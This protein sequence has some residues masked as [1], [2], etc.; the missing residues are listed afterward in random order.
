MNRGAWW[1]RKLAFQEFRAGERVPPAAHHSAGS[2]RGRTRP[3]R[4]DAAGGQVALV[5]CLVALQPGLAIELH[6]RTS[7]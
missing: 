4:P 2:P 6:A 3:L 1:A 5:R 7:R